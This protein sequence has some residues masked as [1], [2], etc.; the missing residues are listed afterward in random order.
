MTTPPVMLRVAIGKRK[1]RPVVVPVTAKC[2]PKLLVRVGVRFW[3]IPWVAN[4]EYTVIDATVMFVN[5]DPGQ[6]RRRVDEVRILPQVEWGT[7]DLI[8]SSAAD[9]VEVLPSLD[10]VATG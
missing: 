4:A 10:G 7:V 8:H 5:E 9:G 3:S 2:H 1:V 6:A